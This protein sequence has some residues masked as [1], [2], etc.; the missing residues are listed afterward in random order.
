M[1]LHPKHHLDIR[2]SDNSSLLWTKTHTFREYA[3]QQYDSGSPASLK[4]MTNHPQL[5]CLLS[6]ARASPKQ[7]SKA[8]S[9]LMP[10]LEALHLLNQE[11]LIL[12]MHPHPSQCHREAPRPAKSQTRY[13]Q[14]FAPKPP[15]TLLA[16]T[17][18][19][20]R[21]GRRKSFK[22]NISQSLRYHRCCAYL[23]TYSDSVWRERINYRT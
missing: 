6:H 14:P 8:Q 5:T 4:S 20:V 10:N 12:H 11:A 17:Q 21:L 19:S 1:S 3:V 23:G 13:S 18:C 2:I 15:T 22:R 7:L 16:G 9:T